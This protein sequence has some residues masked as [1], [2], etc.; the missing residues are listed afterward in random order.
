M[1]K[2]LLRQ[3][4]RNQ[5]DDVFI[6]KN[7]LFLN[8]ISDAYAQNEQSVK[9]LERSLFLISNELNER[10]QTLNDQLAKMKLVQDKLEHSIGLLNATVNSTGEIYLCMD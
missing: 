3:L 4:K 2:L 10:N 7:D 8:S 6:S 9:M 5:K 1:H